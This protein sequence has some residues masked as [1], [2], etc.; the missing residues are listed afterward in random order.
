[1]SRGYVALAVATKDGSFTREIETGHG[2]DR[3]AN[4]LAFAVEA[5]KMLKDVLD[6]DVK[7]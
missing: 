3:E 7:L 6:R 1:M 2:G 5:L 4:M